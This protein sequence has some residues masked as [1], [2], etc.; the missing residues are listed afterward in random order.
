MLILSILLQAGRGGGLSDMFG[1]G[2]QQQQKMFGA[3][4]NVMMARVT[5]FCAIMFIITSIGLGVITTQ[6]GKSLVSPTSIK[7]MF[8]EETKKTQSNENNF[9]PGN[10]PKALDGE[11]KS[12]E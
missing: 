8:A 2:V 6:R 1:G 7:P 4:T 3:Q 10:K 12:E 9:A 11:T 5:T